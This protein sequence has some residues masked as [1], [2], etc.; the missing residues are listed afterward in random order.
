MYYEQTNNGKYIVKKDFVRNWD[1]EKPWK[2]QK[3]VLEYSVLGEFNTEEEC[4][5]YIINNVH[6]KF[7]L[8]HLPNT[9]GFV[10]Q[11][12]KDEIHKKYFQGA[13][14][15]S[16]IP[17]TKYTIM[18]TEDINKIVNGYTETILKDLWYWFRREDVGDY[19]IIDNKTIQVCQFSKENIDMYKQSQL[20][21]NHKNEIALEVEKII[22]QYVNEP[23]PE[24]V[25]VPPKSVGEAID[26]L[27]SNFTH[28]KKA[29]T[30]TEGWIIL[31]VIMLFEIILI[32]TIP[33]WLLTIIIFLLWRRNEIRKYNGM[34]TKKERDKVDLWDNN[35]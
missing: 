19:I 8:I 16:G 34:Y 2:S 22:R 31:I 27:C 14:S 6:N 12:I 24:Q 33:L 1:L 30:L 11:D 4:Q 35:F 7:K 10:S 5:Q 20:Y 29:P 13:I 3:P 32:D 26:N 28:R 17:K 15:D 9:L 18:S 23:V 21:K 25:I